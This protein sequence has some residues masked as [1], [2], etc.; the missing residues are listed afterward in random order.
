[1][2][3]TPVADSREEA[4]PGPLAALETLRIASFRYLL[5]GNAFA[6]LGFQARQMAQAW[7]VLEMTDSD[8]WVGAANGVPAIP[9]I[10]LT[11]FGGELEDYPPVDRSTEQAGHWR[12]PRAGGFI[13]C[14]P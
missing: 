12:D 6:M 1:M 2:S 9:V 7:L 11:L 13:F 8:A 5:F 14:R 10:F 3:S 4:R